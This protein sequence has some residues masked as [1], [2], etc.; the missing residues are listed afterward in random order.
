MENVRDD[1]EFLTSLIRGIA[2]QF[3]N[4]CEVVLHDLTG[5]YDSTIVAIENGHVTGRKVGDPGSNLGLEVLRG[6]VKEGDRYNYLTQTKDGKLLRSSTIYLRNSKQETI[7]S[8]CINFDI[9]DFM[10]AE[11][12]IKSLTLRDTDQEV[13]EVFVNDVN[14]LLDFLL[15]ECQNEIGK[16][17][18]HMSKEEKMQ[19]IEFLDKRGA[20]L[21][22]KAGDKVCKFFDISKFTLYN[23]LDDI[24]S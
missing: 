19:A 8:I 7:G 2:A 14:E 4:R 16:P 23:Y 12:A 21:I 20:F 10:M 17:V 11:N 13:K 24:R 1:F 22:K 6:T 9:S 18:S 15:Q 3:G 5:D